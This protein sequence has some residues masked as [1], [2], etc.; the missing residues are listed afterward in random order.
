MRM[1]SFFKFREEVDDRG[2]GGLEKVF[3]EQCDLVNWRFYG[4]VKGI[5]YQNKRIE[6]M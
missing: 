4:K 5:S 1:S 3:Q 6:I 2:V